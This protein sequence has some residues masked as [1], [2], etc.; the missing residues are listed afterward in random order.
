M[1]HAGLLKAYVDP[2]SQSVKAACTVLFAATVSS[3]GKE[4][5]CYQW[6]HNGSDIKEETDNV[7]ILENATETSSGCISV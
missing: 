4:N 1:Y 5:F 2:P 6:K 3:V 7:I